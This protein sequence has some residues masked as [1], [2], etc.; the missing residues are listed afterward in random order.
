M[1]LVRGNVSISV[2][3]E[4]LVKINGSNKTPN[5]IVGINSEYISDLVH[6][7]GTH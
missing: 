3:A 1:L 7:T 2:I 5:R 4:Q 6:I